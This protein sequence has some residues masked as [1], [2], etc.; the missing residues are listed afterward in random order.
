MH[1]IGL[2]V[3]LFSNDSEI[4]KSGDLCF[5]HWIIDCCDLQGLIVCKHVLTKWF[6]IRFKSLR[7]LLHE[8]AELTNRLN[9]NC[10]REVW[11]KRFPMMI[12][13]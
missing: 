10:E 8:L 9:C 1:S 11:M 13:I 12:A 2:E 6:K 4:E 3:V 7:E 5:P